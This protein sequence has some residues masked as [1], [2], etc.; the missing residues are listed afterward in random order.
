MSFYF[1]SFECKVVFIVNRIFEKFVLLAN[2]SSIEQSIGFQLIGSWIVNEAENSSHNNL[3]LSL[4]VRSIYRK[5]PANLTT[6]ILLN[7]QI[8]A[9]TIFFVL[10]ILLMAPY[11]TLQ[12]I[13]SHK[14]KLKLT[15]NINLWKRIGNWDR[16]KFGLQNLNKSKLSLNCKNL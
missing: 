5:S 7:L 10:P 14:L 4:S 12:V 16:T 1:L 15:I 6:F 13:L 8:I 9:A 2:A 11:K 3:N